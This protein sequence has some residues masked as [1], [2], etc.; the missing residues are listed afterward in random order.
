MGFLDK[1]SE[2][3]C[4]IHKSTVLAKSQFFHRPRAQYG[5]RK[6][7]LLKWRKRVHNGPINGSI[8]GFP[9]KQWFSLKQWYVKTWPCFSGEFAKSV[10]TVWEKCRNDT[11]NWHHCLTPLSTPFMT[12]CG[13]TVPHWCLTVALLWEFSKTM[14]NVSELWKMSQNYGN[15]SVLWKFFSFMEISQ[16]YGNPSVF[17]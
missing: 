6:L 13:L 4:F 3:H 11:T 5:D 7:K 8:T 14:E 17:R 9:L 16:F 2:N 15:F 10:K 12:N 1:M